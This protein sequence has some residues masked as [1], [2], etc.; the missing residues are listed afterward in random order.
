MQY[1]QLINYILLLIAIFVIVGSLDKIKQFGQ[2][3]ETGGGEDKDNNRTIL[4]ILPLFIIMSFFIGCYCSAK[5]VENATGWFDKYCGIF[6]LLGIGVILL[7]SNSLVFNKEQTLRYIA[8]QKFSKTGVIMV[9]GIGALIFGFIDNFGMRLGTEAL[10]DVF[11]QSFLAPLSSHFKFSKHKANIQE[12][13]E[14]INMWNERDWRKVMNHVLRFQREI[15]KYDEFKDLS[16]VIKSYDCKPLNIPKQ[17]LKDRSVTNDYVDNLRSKYDII[18]GSKAMLGNTFSNFCAGLLGAG[19]LGV[20]TVLTAFDNFDVGDRELQEDYADVVEQFSPLLEAFFISVGCLIP[21]IL[22]IAMKRSDNDHN[23]LYA[24]S[25]IAAILFLI[26]FIMYYSFKTT[27]R[28]TTKN[29]ENGI[30]NTLKLIKLR[31][32]ISEKRDSEI[33]NKIDV[34]LS[35]LKTGRGVING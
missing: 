28:L 30:S 11:V 34:F 32:E 24:W 8:G 12:N 18:H 27:K 19:I 31:Y 5:I 17:I 9:L 29:K 10:D 15:G 13:F 33:N 14:I 16:D 4:L 1:S 2:S 20:I 22:N 26:I 25:F 3:S 6:Y 35:S 23:N 7:V 21:I